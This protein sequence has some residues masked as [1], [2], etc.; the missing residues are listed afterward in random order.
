MEWKAQ[1]RALDSIQ[2]NVSLIQLASSDRIALF[3]ISRFVPGNTLKD[4]VSPTLKRILESPNITKVGV[5]AK[6]DS[7]RLRKFLGID[8]RAIFELSHLHRLVKYYHSNPALINKRVV[9]LNEQVEEHFGLPLEKDDDVRCSNWAS[10]LTY[11][12]VQYAAADAYACYQLFHTMDAKRMALDPLPP[13]PA[14][15]ELDRPIR[16]VDE[17]SMNLDPA[18]HQDTESVKSLVK[19]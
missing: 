17:D 3:Q 18:D 4:L 12:Q 10:P 1:A 8:A 16:L 9:R 14:H 6:A 19:S 7:S 5:A 15:A 2:D 11:R 13:L